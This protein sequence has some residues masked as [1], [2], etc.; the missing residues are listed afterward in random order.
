MHETGIRNLGSAI[1]LQA[2]RDYLAKNATPQSKAAIIKD[3]RS[4]WMYM[5]SNGTSIVVAE[6]LERNPEEIRQRLRRNEKEDI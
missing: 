4:A 6:Q 3:L 1:V 2:V 5:L